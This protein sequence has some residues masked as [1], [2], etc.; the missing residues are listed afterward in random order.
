V[1]RLIILLEYDT[2]LYILTRACANAKTRW[3]HVAAG[4][5]H[6]A[7]L[8]LLRQNKADLEAPNKVCVRGARARARARATARA[9]ASERER[10]RERERERER[11]KKAPLTLGL[12]SF[13]I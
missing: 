11:D 10:A 1:R 3:V 2:A 13:L 5:G 8:E 4:E 7:I 9:R 6:D 12:L